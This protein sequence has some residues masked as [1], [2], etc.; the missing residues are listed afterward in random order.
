M[1]WNGIFAP[2]KVGVLIEREFKEL[3]GKMS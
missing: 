1:G 2:K 3:E